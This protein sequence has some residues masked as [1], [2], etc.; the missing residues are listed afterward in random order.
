MAYLKSIAAGI[1]TAIVAVLLSAVIVAI[2][3]YAWLQFQMW[4]L[5]GSGSGGIGAVSAGIAE[6]IVFVALTLGVL[7][8]AGGFWWQ[9]RRA[10]R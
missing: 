10:S 4:R 6:S 2:A 5:S 3:G 7:A 1:A 9:F 8:F